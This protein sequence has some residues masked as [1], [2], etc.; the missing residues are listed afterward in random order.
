MPHPTPPHPTSPMNTCTCR[1]PKRSLYFICKF[2]WTLIH[3]PPY[4]TPPTSTKHHG[5]VKAVVELF[6]YIYTLYIYIYIHIYT[7]YIL[8]ILL[9]QLGWEWESHLTNSYL[10]F[11]GPYWTRLSNGSPNF[12]GVWNWGIHGYTLACGRHTHQMDIQIWILKW[13]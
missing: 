12:S 13:L 3:A 6:I 1:R 9:A 2:T 5:R 4:P 10:N 8:L 11:V 7:I